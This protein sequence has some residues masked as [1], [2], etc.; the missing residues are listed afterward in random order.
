M[1]RLARSPAVVLSTPLTRPLSLSLFTS[2]L[3]FEAWALGVTTSA[4]GFVFVA[5]ACFCGVLR[6]GANPTKTLVAL[7][8]NFALLAGPSILP[9]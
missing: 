7:N 8:Q 6:F 9:L 4:V 3:R 1:A 2:S 5:S